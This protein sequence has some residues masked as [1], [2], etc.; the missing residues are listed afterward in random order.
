MFE[1]H[2]LI[3]ICVVLAGMLGLLLR[4]FSWSEA[5][6]AIITAGALLLLGQVQPDQ[7]LTAIG[8]GTDV[9]LFL[10]GMMLVAELARRTGVFNYLAVW[11]VQKANG[12]SFRLFC[13]IYGV[14]VVVTVFLSNDA[15]AV[16]LTP[17][18]VAAVR[19]A[20]LQFSLPHLYACA[21]VA[22]A[23]SFVL[24]MSNPANLVVFGNQMPGLF[25]WLM[26]FTLPSLLAIVLTFYALLW[27]Q[28]PALKEVISHSPERLTLG[29]DGKRAVVAI[30]LFGVILLVSSAY[31]GDLGI[32]GAFAGIVALILVYAKKPAQGWQAFKSVSW[33]V[34]PLVG[35]LFV[36]VQ[37]LENA[38]VTNQLAQLIAQ[39]HHW[40]PPLAAW[41]AGMASGF[42]SNLV[43]NLPAG[44]FA[45]A[46]ME[47]AQAD[48]A[49][50]AAVLV[51]IDLGPNLSLTG[52]LA[53]LL[54][55]AALRREGMNVTGFQFLKMGMVTLPVPLALTLLA[56][57]TQ[58]WI[59]GM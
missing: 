1:T 36:I 37:A 20:R 26:V 17:A 55:L 58:F 35:G 43:N 32:P 34:I 53:T 28:R 9:Y 33:A 30:F 54:W 23:A 18:V 14:G 10:A 22:N 44:L 13:W 7:A 11:A 19:A 16:V 25:Q 3:I 38:G 50:Q 2:F 49:L 29:V 5:R 39:L 52:S 46:V 56:L 15:T 57:V 41:F 40:S 59:M 4:A 48:L 42:A 47:Q 45:G 31:S 51:G 27:H 8:Q 21:L 24:P 6:W 12:S